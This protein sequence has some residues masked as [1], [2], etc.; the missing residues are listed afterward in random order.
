MLF[1]VAFAGCGGAAE[2]PL[3]NVRRAAPADEAAQAERNAIQSLKAFCTARGRKRD[4]VDAIA[5]LIDHARRDIESGGDDV[6]L[7]WRADLGWLAG[8]LERSECLPAQVPRID[9][10][11]RLLP[12]PE[13]I[14]PEEVYEPEYGYGPPYP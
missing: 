13:L 14:E 10:A 11:L 5:L 12:L 3:D 2:Q 4:A 6:N 7:A 9:R 8:R 1:A